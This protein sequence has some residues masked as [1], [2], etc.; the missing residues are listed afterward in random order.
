M[1]RWKAAGIAT[2]ITCQLTASVSST[3]G[4]ASLI[5]KSF[6]FPHQDLSSVPLI[7][8]S[9]SQNQ[10]NLLIRYLLPLL[11]TVSALLLLQ[12][13]GWHNN[14]LLERGALMFARGFE[15]CFCRYQLPSVNWKCA[16]RYP[17]FLDHFFFHK[18]EMALVFRDNLY[19]SA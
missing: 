13:W 14:R 19:M 7:Q 18:K 8:P 2:S 6:L 4:L 17:V 3:L 10:T 9:T 11:A 5:L 16:S 1:T 12:Y 15:H